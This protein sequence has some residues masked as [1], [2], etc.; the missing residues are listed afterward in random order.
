MGL[1]GALYGA[2]VGAL[3]GAETGLKGAAVINPGLAIPAA[4]VCCSRWGSSRRRDD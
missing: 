3:A 2:L 4:V 1:L